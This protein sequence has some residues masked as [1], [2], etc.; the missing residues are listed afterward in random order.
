MASTYLLVIVGGLIG[1]QL[2]FSCLKFLKHLRAAKRSGL[3]YTWSL[4]HELEA[5]A[6]VTD[7]LLRWWYRE[8]LERG[9][10]WPRWAR[11]MVKD[12]HYEDHRR[13]TLEYGD[14]FLVVTPNALV[15]Y[16]SDPNATARLVTRRKAFIKPAD[17]MSA[18]DLRVSDYAFGLI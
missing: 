9:E 11:F 7:A 3:P 1:A 6:F 14:V 13:G 2:L 4:I 16:I 10:G 18:R 12:W 8:R 15:C 5:K 17:K